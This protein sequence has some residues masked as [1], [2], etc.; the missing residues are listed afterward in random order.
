MPEF[1]KT[2]RFRYTLGLLG[3][4]I[5]PFLLLTAYVGSA[6]TQRDRNLMGEE[7]MLWVS[8]LNGTGFLF[9]LP[10]RLPLRIA[11]GIVYIL[12]MYIALTLWMFAYVCGRFNT[13]L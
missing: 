6:P 1:W 12:P 13:C 3:A 11:F 4:G 7:I 9:L 5:V 10:I 2:D 8:L